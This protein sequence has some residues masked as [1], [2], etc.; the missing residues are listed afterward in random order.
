MQAV[1]NHY[2]RC[3]A[4]HD[5]AARA[6]LEL[7][8]GHSITDAEWVDARARLAGFVSILRAWDRAAKTITPLRG[9]VEVPCQPEP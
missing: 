3:R 1:N 8:V 4:Q 7:R 9:N 2:G 5:V 6:A